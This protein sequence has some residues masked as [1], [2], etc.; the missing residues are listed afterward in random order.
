MGRPVLVLYGITANVF[1]LICLVLDGNVSE[2]LRLLQDLPIQL[3]H[4]EMLLP[5]KMLGV[6]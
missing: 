5:L 3:P 6:F 1:M 2:Q 4:P